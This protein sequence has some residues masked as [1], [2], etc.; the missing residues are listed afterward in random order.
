MVTRE[1]SPT[2]SPL[3]PFTPPSTSDNWST[4]AEGVRGRGRAWGG[5]GQPD[6]TGG[7]RAR[8]WIEDAGWKKEEEEISGKRR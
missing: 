4:G 6:V 1:G 5:G 3:H 7:G 2:L 8:W